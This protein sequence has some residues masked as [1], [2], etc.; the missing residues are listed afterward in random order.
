MRIPGRNFYDATAGRRVE[1]KR[2]RADQDR[3]CVPASFRVGLWPRDFDSA[4][5]LILGLRVVRGRCERL[6]DSEEPRPE[7]LW[8][9]DAAG[10]APLWFQGDIDHALSRQSR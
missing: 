1:A 6:Q 5:T 3:P 10:A 7:S 4:K 2:K 8:N 9:P